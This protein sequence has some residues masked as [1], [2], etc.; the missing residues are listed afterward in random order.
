MSDKYEIGLNG[1]YYQYYSGTTQ[2]PWNLPD[3]IIKGDFAIRPIPKLT[4]LAYLSLLSGIHALDNGNKPVSL[5][6]IT[7]LGAN[8]EYQFNMRVDVFLQVSNIL[9]ENYQ[10]WMGYKSYGINIYGGIR[11]KF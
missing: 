8:G 2:Y 9:N 11:L 6:T 7:D 10:Q 1:K 5:K 4:I 3:L